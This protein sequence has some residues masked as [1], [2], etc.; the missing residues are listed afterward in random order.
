[1]ISPGKKENKIFFF[2]FF[3]RFLQNTHEELEKI[4]Q[5]FQ[6]AIHFH[7]EPSAIRNG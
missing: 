7:P 5:S 6:V 2:F 3:L 1:M 4:G